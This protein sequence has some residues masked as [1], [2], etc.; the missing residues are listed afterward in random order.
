MGH[1]RPIE[2]LTGI[3][4]IGDPSASLRTSLLFREGVAQ[5]I[6]SQSF[7]TVPVVG[8]DP[9]PYMDAEATVVPVHQFFD[10]LIANLA[11]SFQHGQNF[12]T[13]DLFQLFGLPLGHA[14][15]DAIG[16]KK[17]VGDNGMKVRMK[18]G[19][20]AEGVDHHDHPEDAVIEPQHRAKEHLQALVRTVAELCQELPVVLEI[21]AQH[22]RDAEDE[23][24]MRDWVKDVVGD[25]FSELNRFLGMATGA[26]PP[27]LA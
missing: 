17:A 16:C 7:L 5:D 24:P 2:D 13:K 15:E 14:M 22:D 25:V 18:P 23:L 6:F 19:V 12:R 8:G 4:D 9:V 27:S 11:F 21:D 3:L 20:I 1:G 26:E 10:E